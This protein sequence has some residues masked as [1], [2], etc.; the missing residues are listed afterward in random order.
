MEAGT[1][2]ADER[3]QELAGRWMELV[4]EMTGG[5]Q[6]ILRSMNTMWQQEE[7]VGGI[8]TAH[9]RE[10]MDYI[11]KANAASRRPQ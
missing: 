11:G 1:D 7:S 2:P 9:M 6:G 4:E 3:V 5:D 10:L 8:D